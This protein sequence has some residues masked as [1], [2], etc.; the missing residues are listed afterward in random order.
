MGLQLIGKSKPGLLETKL[1]VKSS[2]HRLMGNVGARNS[3]NSL[4][5]DLKSLTS[6]DEGLF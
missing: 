3:I 4:S 1:A 6:S 5:S 2:R